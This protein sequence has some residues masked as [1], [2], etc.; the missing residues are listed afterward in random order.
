MNYISETNEGLIIHFHVQPGASK[1]EISGL[2]GN[3]I[4]VRLKAPPVE[5]RANEELIR[6]L[7]K[8][9]E[10]PKKNIEIISGGLSRQKNVKISGI[11]KD[12]FKRKINP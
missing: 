11:N 6:F 12:L 2:H 8:L 1:S 10:I 4:K 9:L 7:S 3:R 5:G